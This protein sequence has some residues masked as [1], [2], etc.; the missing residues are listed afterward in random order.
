MFLLLPRIQQMKGSDV[1]KNIYDMIRIQQ[2]Q[3]KT[4]VKINDLEKLTCNF[5]QCDSIEDFT[6]FLK[7]Y[8][9]LFHLSS[10]EL[11]VCII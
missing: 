10:D 6:G 3:T 7:K 1:I 11:Y 5:F 8:P 4:Y 2:E 9:Q